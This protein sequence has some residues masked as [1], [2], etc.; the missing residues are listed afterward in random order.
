MLLLKSVVGE[1]LASMLYPLKIF[2]GSEFGMEMPDL[3]THVVVEG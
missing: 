2:R 3:A 1:A